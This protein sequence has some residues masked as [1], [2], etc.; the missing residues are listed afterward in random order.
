MYMYAYKMQS[1][2]GGCNTLIQC[3]ECSSQSRT[4]GGAGPEA[5]GLPRGV[6]QR[7]SMVASLR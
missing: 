2:S 7:R 5:D 6:K 4:G 1:V 3:S